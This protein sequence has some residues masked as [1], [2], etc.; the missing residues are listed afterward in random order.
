MKL[1][2]NFRRIHPVFHVSNLRPYSP[3]PIH[4][5]HPPKP[6]TTIIANDG[7]EEYEVETILDSRLYRGKLQY[8]VRWKGYG[9]EE[10]SWEP[11]ANLKNA[12]TMITK[13]HKDNPNSPRRI[14]AAIWKTLPFKRF[15]NL[16][17]PPR[18]VLF[19]WTEGRTR[20]DDES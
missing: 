15:E 17:V 20:R 18:R 3:D 5:R 9:P 13:F 2:T 8:L 11:E 10:N 14:S 6:P 19:N 1:T 16:T 4:E 12:K 7:V